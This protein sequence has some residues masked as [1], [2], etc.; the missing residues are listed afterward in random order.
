[1]KTEAGYSGQ[2]EVHKDSTAPDGRPTIGHYIKKIL[3]T[4][5]NDAFNRLY[6]FLGQQYINDNFRK[7]AYPNVQILHR[8]DIF[9]SDR[10]STRLNSSHLVI[11]YAVFCL[12]K[13]KQYINP[14]SQR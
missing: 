10:K 1:M 14:Y 13:K 3:L 11:S 5:D 8:L 9:L 12:K 7:K 2:T 6:E 4:S